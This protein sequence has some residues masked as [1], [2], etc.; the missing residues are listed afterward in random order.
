MKCGHSRF[1]LSLQ[2]P[3]HI[4]TLTIPS[5]ATAHAQTFC[6][7]AVKMSTNRNKHSPHAVII[8]KFKPKKPDSRCAFRHAFSEGLKQHGWTTSIQENYEPADLIVNWGIRRQDIIQQAR[9]DGCE[10]CILERGYVGDRKYWTSVSFGGNLNGRASFFIPHDAG[11]RWSRLF[12]ETMCEFD[13][14]QD[15][16][17]LVIG[18]VKKDMS[19][20]HADIES[21]HKKTHAKL[22]ERGWTVYFR[23][24]PNKKW[25]L[26]LKYNTYYRIDQGDLFT[27][28]DGAKVVVTFNSNTG[29]D[30]VLQGRPVIACDQG[31]MVWALSG[32]S[33]DEIVI[34]DRQA[35][36]SKIA[37]CQYSPKEISSGWAWEQISEARSEDNVFNPSQHSI[38]HAN[39]T[40]KV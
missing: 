34:P 4:Q 6:F 31:S 37:W 9:Q 13:V 14:P 26:K 22:E 32:N 2:R 5:V 18:Q 21:W 7:G 36:A 27:A 20:D 23:P 15:G 16:Y 1:T 17:A 28:V 3:C 35:W 29:V 40:E 12:S 30:A 19:V 33:A 25:I 39:R 38:S 24:H 10:I 8:Q 11:E